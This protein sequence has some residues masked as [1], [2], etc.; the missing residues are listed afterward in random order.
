MTES[1]VIP[2]IKHATGVIHELL[3]MGVGISIDDFGTGHSSLASIRDLSPTEVKI[4]QSFVRA[5][6]TSPRDTAMVRA[7]RRPVILAGVE[8][9]RFG[10]QCELLEFASGAG[11]PMAAT[12]L[13]KAR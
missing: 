13:G 11:I 4:D 6:A 5:S 9:H 12:M 3:A 1:S 7:A 2:D 8:I 10:L